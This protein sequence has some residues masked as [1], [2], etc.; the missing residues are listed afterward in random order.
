MHLSI[1]RVKGLPSPSFGTEESVL[2][3]VGVWVGK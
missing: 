1:S 2:T 3:S